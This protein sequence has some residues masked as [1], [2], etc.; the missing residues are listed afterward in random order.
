VAATNA[1]YTST[2]SFGVI[3]GDGQVTTT[4]TALA[5]S[6]AVLGI[7]V[8]WVSAT[9]CATVSGGT[10]SAIA[11]SSVLTGVTLIG[12]ADSDISFLVT[13]TAAGTPVVIKSYTV[14]QHLQLE[15]EL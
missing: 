1:T 4:G 11:N 13:P 14:R 7:G 10:I 5:Y 6:T 15:L 12:D 3:S 8:D 9:I 2:T